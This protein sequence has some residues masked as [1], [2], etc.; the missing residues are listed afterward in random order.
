MGRNGFVDVRNLEPL[1]LV[2][3]EVSPD[4]SCGGTKGYTCPTTA[5]KC[6]SQYGT[7]LVQFIQLPLIVSKTKT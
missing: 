1:G 2:K 7:L 4:G 5:N 6:C 3:R